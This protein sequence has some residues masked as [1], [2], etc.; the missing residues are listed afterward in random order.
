MIT[1]LHI[2]KREGGI[3]MVS[4]TYKKRVHDLV[5]RAK[6]KGKIIKYSDFSKSKLAEDAKLD[7]EE[8][9]YYISE[10]EEETN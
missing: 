7:E 1:I 9:T 5:N 10:I 4:E 3:K 2:I 6:E 8:V